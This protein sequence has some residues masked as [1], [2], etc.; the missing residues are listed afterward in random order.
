MLSFAF[1]SEYVSSSSHCPDL[2]QVM[3]PLVVN[4]AS[5]SQALLGILIRRSKID[6]VYMKGKLKYRAWQAWR[7]LGQ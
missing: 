1:A 4:K 5:I 6:K 7:R 3:G 2:S